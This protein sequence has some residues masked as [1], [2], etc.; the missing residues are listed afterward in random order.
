[1][2]FIGVSC[3]NSYPDQIYL[4]IESK[5][6]MLP[7]LKVLFPNKKFSNPESGE[8]VTRKSFSNFVSIYRVL[9]VWIIPI[10]VIL[11]HEDTKYIYAKYH[12]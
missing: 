5:E 9:D 8:Y 7:L 10:E 11:E 3:F 12:C 1:M 6:A 4:E 2:K